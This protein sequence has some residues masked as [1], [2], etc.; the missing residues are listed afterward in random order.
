M[1]AVNFGATSE[2]MKDVPHESYLERAEEDLIIVHMYPTNIVISVKLM[3][4]VSLPPPFYI[5]S[6]I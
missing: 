6:D 2:N 4:A 3:A 5:R 1:Q